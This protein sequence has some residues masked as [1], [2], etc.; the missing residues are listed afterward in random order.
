MEHGDIVEKGTHDELIAAQVRTTGFY[1]SQFEQAAADLDASE[2]MSEE[3]G[4][5][6]A[7]VTGDSE[8]VSAMALLPP[9]WSSRRVSTGR[10][11]RRTVPRRRRSLTG[12]VTRSGP[13][14]RLAIRSG[15]SLVRLASARPARPCG[16]RPRDVHL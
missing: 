9:R 4:E 16:S 5:R 8:V 12:R 1:R 15:S 2:S 14:R 10:R 7:R 3:S 6:P 11:V 13:R